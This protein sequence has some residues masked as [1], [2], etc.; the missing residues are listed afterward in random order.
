MGIVGRRMVVALPKRV[1]DCVVFREV[2]PV[3]ATAVF[4]FLAEPKAGQYR[5][6]TDVIF[7]GCAVIETHSSIVD[8]S[9][10]G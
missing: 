7:D 3:R 10:D 9:R 6:Q 8:T 1:W 5:L 4:D 2:E